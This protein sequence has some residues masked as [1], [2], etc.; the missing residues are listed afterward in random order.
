MTTVDAEV[1]AVRAA[2]IDGPLRLEDGAVRG[3]GAGA[4]R[5]TPLLLAGLDGAYAVASLT[6]DTPG[7]VWVV[8]LEPGRW[9]RLDDEASF[10]ELLAA[11]PDL[12]AGSV[13]SVAA[14]TLGPSGGERVLFTSSEVDSLLAELAPRIAPGERD[15]VERTGPGGGRTIAFLGASLQ[16]RPPDGLFRLTVAR[17]EVTIVPGGSPRIARRELLSDALLERYRGRDPS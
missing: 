2:G 10:A 14:A 11:I 8:E 12:P 3:P 4:W 7:G 13:A 5:V 15:F 1:A 16:P 17:W 9:L 6:T